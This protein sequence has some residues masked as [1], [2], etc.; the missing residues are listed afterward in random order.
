VGILRDGDNA[1]VN[2]GSWQRGATWGEVRDGE[3]LLRGVGRRGEDDADEVRV[4]ER[5]PLIESR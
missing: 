1:L 4:L 5:L 2:L 3:L